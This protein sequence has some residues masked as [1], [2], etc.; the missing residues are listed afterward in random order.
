MLIDTS[1]L[2]DHRRSAAN[3]VRYVEPLV[4]RGLVVAHPVVVFE[5]LAGVR[6]KADFDATRV[7]VST[8]K[9]AAVRDADF[10]VAQKF[11]E[12]IGRSHGVG[13]P[14]C[15]IAATALRMRL[16]LVT[17]NGRHFSHFR[18]LKVIVPY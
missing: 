1:V 14:D 10:L 16:P 12:S 8:M 7:Q 6:S 11:L 15:L 18:G 3:A 17:L 5:L 13:W 9:R 2:I 4:A